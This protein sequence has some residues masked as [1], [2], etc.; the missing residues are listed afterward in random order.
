M[1]LALF[2]FDGTITTKDTLFDFTHF[3]VSRLTFTL[4]MVVLFLPM[5][6]HKIGLLSA[7][8]TKEIF[9]SYFF[10]NFS[11]EAF[12]KHCNRFAKDRLPNLIRSEALNTINQHKEKGDTVIIVSASP[13]NWI[14]PWA[15]LYG[16]KVIAT[17]LQIINNQLTGQIMGANCNGIEKVN[18]IHSEINLSDYTE[19]TAYGDSIGDKDMLALAQKRYLKPFR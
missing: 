9:L 2:D 5:L 11:R 19:I 15:E 12:D 13:E 14:K 4:G 6:L 8:K 18:R 17:K 1:N 10:K 7:H 16:I 3:S